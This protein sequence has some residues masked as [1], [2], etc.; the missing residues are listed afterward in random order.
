MEVCKVQQYPFSEQQ[1][2]RALVSSCRTCSLPCC[3]SD[4]PTHTLAHAHTYTRTHT[5]THTHTHAHTHTHTHPYTHAPHALQVS[6]ADWEAYVA[7]I[8]SDII[9][10]QSPKNLFLVRHVQ[11][12]HVLVHWPHCKIP[13]PFKSLFS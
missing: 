13:L 6:P 5:Y 1:Q 2:V 4:E 9:R 10:E 7:E 3:S 11:S 8:A 12:V